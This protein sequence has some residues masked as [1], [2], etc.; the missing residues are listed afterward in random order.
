MIMID[1]TIASSSFSAFFYSYYDEL[2]ITVGLT[3]MLVSINGII[4]ALRKIREY[5]FN[6]NNSGWG[7]SQSVLPPKMDKKRT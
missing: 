5:V 2:I 6:L 3:Q 4:T 1:Q 7:Y